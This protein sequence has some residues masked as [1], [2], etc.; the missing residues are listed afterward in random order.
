MVTHN[1]IMIY[2]MNIYFLVQYKIE[3][4]IHVIIFQLHKII[5]KLFSVIILCIILIIYITAVYFKILFLI[6]RK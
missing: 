1:I 2:V 3:I 4:L 5:I 6:F